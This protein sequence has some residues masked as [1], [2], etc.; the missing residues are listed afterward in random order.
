MFRL[1]VCLFFFEFEQHEVMLVQ[2]YLVYVDVLR[3]RRTG[4]IN[5]FLQGLA[6]CLSHSSPLSRVVDESDLRRRISLFESL[7]LLSNNR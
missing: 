7:S 3:Y 5:P 6:S 1:F 2:P 4:P